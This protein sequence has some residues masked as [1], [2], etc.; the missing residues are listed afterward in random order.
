MAP[1]WFA[2]QLEQTEKLLTAV[3][4]LETRN[5]YPN[6]A[7]YS[8]S[9]AR[10]LSYF[11]LWKYCYENQYFDFILNDWSLV[12]LRHSPGLSYSFLDCPIRTCTYND[13]CEQ[14]LEVPTDQWG[15]E[16]RD[17]YEEYIMQRPL[18]ES[19]TPARYDFAPKDYKSGIHPASHFHLGHDSNIRLATKHIIKPLA[20]GLFVCR[21]FFPN[22]WEKF[23]RHSNK[24][25][26]GKHASQTLEQIDDSLFSDDDKFE[27]WLH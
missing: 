3:D 5:S 6:Y 21:Q 27:L 12:I 18:K 15:E 24:Q 7:A 20:F 4:L 8:V 17:L 14:I 1:G 22:H 16:Y 25:D 23:L 13:F 11:E 26:W 19:V 2:A 10:E 9:L